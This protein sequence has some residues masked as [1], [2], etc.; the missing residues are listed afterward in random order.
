MVSA[1]PTQTVPT[2]FPVILL[3]PVW[4]FRSSW[5]SL[6]QLQ[7]FLCITQQYL[8]L[9]AAK[10][11]VSLFILRQ[12]KEQKT[13][14]AIL[15]FLD[16]LCLYWEVSPSCTV[17]PLDQLPEWMLVWIL[18]IFLTLPYLLGKLVCSATSCMSR[19][20]L[21][22]KRHL[23]TVHLYLLRRKKKVAAKYN[24]CLEF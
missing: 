19:F 4:L 5:V 18:L 1:P 3:V 9:K 16:C 15:A 21:V 11:H 6:K 12:W 8:Y 24:Y 20:D 22:P 13:K 10:S 2:V 14:H 23:Y 7:S 17:S